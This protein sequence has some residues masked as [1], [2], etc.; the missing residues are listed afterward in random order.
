MDPRPPAS[1]QTEGRARALRSFVRSFVHLQPSLGFILETS[2]GRN[3]RRTIPREAGNLPQGGIDR[4]K[5]QRRV[6]G[7]DAR[8]SQASTELLF[9]SS[10]RGRLFD[11]AITVSY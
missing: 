8:N 11:R 4:V 5:E 1:L 7:R 6:P 9:S 2:D 3:F 10:P